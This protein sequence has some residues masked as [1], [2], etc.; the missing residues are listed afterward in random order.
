MH[1]LKRE[2]PGLSPWLGPQEH[3]LAASRG[4]HSLTCAGAGEVRM[5]LVRR[6]EFCTPDSCS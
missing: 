1:V 5:T 6:E 2:V 4:S 3:R